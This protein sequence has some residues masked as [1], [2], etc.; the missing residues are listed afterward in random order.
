MSTEDKNLLGNVLVQTPAYIQTLKAKYKKVYVPAERAA[1]KKTLDPIREDPQRYLLSIPLDDESAKF[2]AP[3][4][5]ICGRQDGVVGYRDSLRLLEL[6]PRSTYA[7]LDRGTH[8][9][10]IDETGV[11][12]AL[13][14]DWIFRVNEWRD[15]T[16]T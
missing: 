7:V 4:L 10:P 12:E 3:A 2:L 9:L 11:F 15:R 8:G 13:V 5:V 16:D 14:R 1:D 6:Y